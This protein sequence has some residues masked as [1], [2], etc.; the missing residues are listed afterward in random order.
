MTPLLRLMLSLWHNYNSTM[1]TL[2]LPR[3]FVLCKST[4]S[5]CLSQSA[6]DNTIL[7]ERV[8]Y[9]SRYCLLFGVV[10]SVHSALINIMHFLVSSSCVIIFIIRAHVW[11]NPYWLLPWYNWAWPY[12]VIPRKQNHIAM[13]NKILLVT[14]YTCAAV[15]CS[16]Y[17]TL[18][19]L[20]EGRVQTCYVNT[21]G[22]SQFTQPI[23][24]PPFKEV[25]RDSSTV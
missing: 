24:V 7:K 20:I 8:Q 15:Q 25:Q 13:G 5:F 1:I 19:T 10:G 2:W 18:W 16:L 21:R 4:T 23:L 6:I 12:L 17:C 22:I 14:R 9:S 11:R 3:I